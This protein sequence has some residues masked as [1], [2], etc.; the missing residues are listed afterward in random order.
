MQPKLR[1]INLHYIISAKSGTMDVKFDFQA[2]DYLSSK[3]D[4][5]NILTPCRRLPAA[6]QS[7]EHSASP[8]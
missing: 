6:Q 5:T 8:V 3:F 1:E 4:L 7:A 2:F